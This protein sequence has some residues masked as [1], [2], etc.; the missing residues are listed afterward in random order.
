MSDVEMVRIQMG[1]GSV[2]EKRARCGVEGPKLL[3]CWMLEALLDKEESRRSP[4]VY[5]GPMVARDHDRHRDGLVINLGAKSI[6]FANF[7]PFCG[8]SIKTTYP[9]AADAE[10]GGDA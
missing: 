1:D 5:V 3:E 2:M 10:K 7:C 6:F 8:V 9:A 4:R